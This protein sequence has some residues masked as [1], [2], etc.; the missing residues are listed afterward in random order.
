MDFHLDFMKERHTK[1][2]AMSAAVST[3]PLVSNEHALKLLSNQ[4]ELY[5]VMSDAI[6]YGVWLADDKGTS[7][8]VSQSFLDLLQMTFD[9]YVL[10]GL[11]HRLHPDDVLSDKADWR[12]CM[13][14]GKHRDFEH[15]LLGPDGKYHYVLTRGEPIY[16]ETGKIKMWVGINLDIDERKHI[17]EENAHLLAQIEH[18]RQRI[19]TIIA[20]VPGM[21]WEVSGS[22]TDPQSTFEYVS[23][24]AEELYGYPL[25]DWLS[26]PNFRFKIMHPDDLERV[27]R[28]LNTI[29]QT[30]TM[31]KVEFR[32]ICKDAE[33]I[34]V[35][36]H[37][38]VIQDGLGRPIAM[39]GVTTDITQRK[40]ESERKDEFLSIASHELKTPITSIRGFT[41]IL[42]RQLEDLSY[43]EVRSYLGKVNTYVDKLMDIIGELLDISRIQTGKLQLHMTSF[44]LMQLAL[45]TIQD[46]QVTTKHIIEF[47]PDSKLVV[48]VAKE[49]YRP[50]MIKGDGK[51]LAQVIINLLANAIKYSPHASKI[52]VSLAEKNGQA[53]FSVKD[54]GIGIPKA[55]QR[56]I[57]QR[58]YRVHENESAYSGLG[59]GL[60]ICYK[61][62]Q[63]HG[64]EMRVD[65]AE[66]K[67]STFYFSLPLN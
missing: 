16:D 8:Y 43:K 65:S 20:R 60:Y 54:F 62:I 33:M 17:E 40:L 59:I 58:Y 38:S 55:K 44:D 23:D 14:T 4:K 57:F 11:D 21:V 51:R 42:D 7:L 45:E 50:V 15:R 63:R 5:R 10:R 56:N 6:P 25:R 41:Q 32:T 31:G 36:S 34:W 67:G 1:K 27:K 26:I 35:E 18:E 48:N 64:G 66:N 52:I 22:P 29:Y 28:E 39:R 53:I 24:Y 46:I 3:N 49:Q 12:I 47:V 30:K 13:E 2:K 37:C 9:E 61:I 19:E